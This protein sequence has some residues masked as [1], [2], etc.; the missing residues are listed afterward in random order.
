MI[1]CLLVCISAFSFLAHPPAQ[2]LKD[3]TKARWSE[4]ANYKISIQSSFR[5]HIIRD[6]VLDNLIK[7]KII[8][9]ED[10][11]S[12]FPAVQGDGNIMSVGQ[13][14]L[15]KNEIEVEKLLYGICMFGQRTNGCW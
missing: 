15:Q 13:H 5:K 8:S 7:I 10:V 3:L 9:K 2:A 1:T 4:L 12:V 6:L 11:E 14:E